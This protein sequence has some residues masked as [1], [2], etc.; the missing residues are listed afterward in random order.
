MTHTLGQEE[1]N[2][3]TVLRPNYPASCITFISNYWPL[4]TIETLMDIIDDIVNKYVR[5]PLYKLIPLYSPSTSNLKQCWK[6]S[7]YT[8]I[9]LLG[10]N[11]TRI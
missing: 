9:R 6:C 5:I 1:I 3:A 11:I 7:L 2:R 10:K 4:D 8:E